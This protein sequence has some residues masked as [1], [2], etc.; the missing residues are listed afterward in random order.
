VAIVGYD[1]TFLAALHHISLTTI[2]QPRPEMG[3]RAVRALVERIDGT[4]TEPLRLRTVPALV[5]RQTTGP[6][7]VDGASL[8]R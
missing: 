1:N 5:V 8:S 4:R 3:R 6:A 7:R 2:D